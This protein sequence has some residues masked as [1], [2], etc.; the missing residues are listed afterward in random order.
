[1]TA[2]MA[3]RVA[4]VAL[5]AMFRPAEAAPPLCCGE[6]VEFAGVVRDGVGGVQGLDAANGVAISPGGEHVY[7]LGQNDQALAVFSRDPSTG[8]LT[9]LEQEVNGVGGVTGITGNVED[10][11][12]S[13]DGRSVYVAGAT[14]S[15]IVAFQR[16]L[17][18]G[19][20]T[21][22]ETEQNGM[23]GVVNMGGP[24][25]VIV[26]PDGEHLYTACG[27]GSVAVFDRDPVT[28]ALTYLESH[29]DGVGGVDGIAR[30]TSVR[31]SPD[32]TSVYVA[33]FNDDSIAV[34]S[35]NTAT[36]ALQ[37]VERE[38]EGVNGV[39]GLVDALG[40]AVSP[41][42]R[43]VYVGSFNNS[44]TTFTRDEGT[45][46]LT[47]VET[48]QNGGS[49][50]LGGPGP[51]LVSPDGTR[52]YVAAWVSSLGV[53][54]RGATSG[55][56]T[57]AEREQEGA[58]GVD[59]LDGSGKIAISPD[60][61]FVYVSG[62]NDDAIA[63]FEVVCRPDTGCRAPVEPNAAKLT[64]KNKTPD[65]ADLLVWKWSKGDATMAAELGD[66]TVDDDYAVCVFDES[67]PNPR[68]L[69]RMEAAAATTCGSNPCWKGLGSPA[70]SKGA[71]YSDRT[72]A[73]G[74][75]QTMLLK[76]GEAGRA[77]IIVKAK[78]ENLAVSE[79]P[80]ALP[81]PLRVQVQA[82]DGLCWEASFTTPL[83]NDGATFRAKGD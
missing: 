13:P 2:R 61:R 81:V 5:L 4:I 55:A 12:V 48:E 20:L 23:G 17:V 30:A 67:G 83:S 11:T 36:G 65:S 3:M 54:A 51:L 41:D 19:L 15:A 56:L 28:G 57:F 27:Q 32:G 33:G 70:L 1:M 9:F 10:V 47:F 71:K 31:V 24:N 25:S 66:P 37:F 52:V 80:Q 50:F 29:V 58:D 69:M 77:K 60:S 76:P 8:G 22:L 16:D 53:F 79:P 42:G 73:S 63:I 74:G 75:L 39:V 43:N 14:A 78:G 34:F 46:A 18:T 45:G 44:V 82:E 40:V 21:F 7:A 68:L 72:R 35:R 49:A 38:T 59:G 26:S 62:F 64:V 6:F